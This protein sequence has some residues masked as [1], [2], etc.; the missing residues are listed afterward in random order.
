MKLSKLQMIA[1][2]CLLALGFMTAAPF[3][4]TADA[5]EVHWIPAYKIH[6]YVCSVTGTLL[7]YDILDTGWAKAEHGA[8]ADHSTFPEAY[9]EIVSWETIPPEERVARTSNTE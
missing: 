1:I 3:V 4:Q 2:V 7:F 9:I 8:D 6:A 5:G